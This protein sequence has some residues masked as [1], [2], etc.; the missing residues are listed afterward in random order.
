V[1]A[2]AQCTVDGN[3]Y[4][5][6]IES[7]T[8]GA[9][10]NGLYPGLLD[11]GAPETLSFGTWSFATASR[12]EITD[13]GSVSGA[14]CAS[15]GQYNAQWLDDC[16]TLQ[17][18]L[19]SDDCTGRVALLSN[20]FT[21]VQ[22]SATADCVSAG[23]VLQTTF[24]ESAS[25]PALSKE[26]ATIVFGSSGFATS[27]VGTRGILFQRWTL[28][29]TNSGETTSIID[30]GSYGDGLA[31]ASTRVGTYFSDWNA[32]CG[33][34]LCGQGD[35]CVSRGELLHGAKFNG[36]QTAN[37]CPRPPNN[38]GLNGF[39]KCNPTANEWT[40][41][42][43]D[44]TEQLIDGGCMFCLGRAN[45]KE[46]RQCL[47]RN[48]VL[49]NDIFN[50]AAGHAYCTLEFECPASTATLSLVVFISSVALLLFR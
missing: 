26:D 49:C 48:G 10:V 9:V 15:T 1:L 16:Q 14:Q 37:V 39:G 5:N 18:S 47:D 21:Q 19:I 25:L 2:S 17:L 35:S 4:T 43:Y 46:A 33:V 41:H 45:G 11:Y 7:L 32:D 34:Q 40:R 8:F 31:C 23:T 3:T 28:S 20:S 36:F 30:L 6:G 22:R 24:Q 44:C 38:P 13:V 29:S 50:S 42:P 12:W 27:S